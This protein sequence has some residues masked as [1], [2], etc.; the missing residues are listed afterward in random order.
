MADQVRFDF[1]VPDELLSAVVAKGRHTEAVADLA[2][3]PG[4]IG[5]V[6]YC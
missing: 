3:M 2:L 1:A 5:K 6:T 4:T